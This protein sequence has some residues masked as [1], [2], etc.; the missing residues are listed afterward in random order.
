M[1]RVYLVVGLVAVAF[2]IYA[3]I[4]CLMT[5]GS[6]ARGI[7]KPLWILV[8]LF[9]PIIGAVLWF[10][11]GKDRSTGRGQVRQLAPDDDPAFLKQLGQE[12]AQQERI[13]RL[14]QE[15]AELDD[16]TKD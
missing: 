7:P 2:T 5:D 10:T 14:E 13:R 12:K 16:D 3:A 8:I 15:L 4:D 9:I 1:V 11:L 6:R